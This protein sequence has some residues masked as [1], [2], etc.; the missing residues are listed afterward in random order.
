MNISIVLCVYNGEKYIEK[1]LSSLEKQTLLPTEI[2]I[3]DDCSTDKSVFLI[4]K[5]LSEN[6]IGQRCQLTVNKKNQGWKKNFANGIKMASGDLI[7]TCDQDDYWKADKIEVMSAMM[8]KNKDIN[9]LVSDYEKYI[10][11]EANYDID[12]N[13][14]P[15]SNQY[16]VCKIPFDNKWFNIRYPGCVFCIRKSLIPL[17]EKYWFETYAHDFCLWHLSIITGSLYR[18][19]YKSIRFRRHK[20]TA[21]GHREK[22]RQERL[23]ASKYHLKVYENLNDLVNSDLVDADTK[24]IYKESYNFFRYRYALLQKFS[25]QNALGLIKYRKFY[26]MKNY[27]GDIYYSLRRS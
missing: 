14:A 20:G 23:A 19:N 15:D 9:V 6:I 11:D 18:T 12:N 27:F 25:I 17:F 1:L 24:K 22:N 3:I 10:E 4:K 13:F 8:D 21:T 26:T 5:F 16:N 2:L 7:F